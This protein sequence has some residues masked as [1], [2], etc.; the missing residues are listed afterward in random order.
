[1]YVVNEQQ[2]VILTSAGFIAIAIV[3]TAIIIYSYSVSLS[4][5][6][7]IISDTAGI[8]IY[9]DYAL[10]KEIKAVNWGELHPNNRAEVTL[11]IKNNGTVPVRLTMFADSW[12]PSNAEN[13]LTI[14]WTYNDSL[15]NP[16][17]YM[18]IDMILDVSPNVTGITDFSCI[19]H[20]TGTSQ[21]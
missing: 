12:N 18:A 19:V 5:G 16:S 17:S 8:Q 9:G 21:T 7:T 20:I 14:T 13:Y 11:W 2:K 15:L 6:G 3:I 4:G 10:T 1:M